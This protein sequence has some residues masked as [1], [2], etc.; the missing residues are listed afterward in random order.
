MKEKVFVLLNI[1][2]TQSSSRQ[3]HRAAVVQAKKITTIRKNII[4]EELQ[5]LKSLSSFI[6]VPVAFESDQHKTAT[7]LPSLCGCCDA[8]RRFLHGIDDDSSH[9]KQSSCTTSCHLLSVSRQVKLNAKS[10]Y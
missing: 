1:W 8:R 5:E 4:W 3:H 7:S 9:Q 2:V 10:L 6:L